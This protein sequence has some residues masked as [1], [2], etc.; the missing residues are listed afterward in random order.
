VVLRGDAL[1]PPLAR[2]AF[3]IVLLDAPCSGTGTLRRRPDKRHRLAAGDIAACAARQAQMLEAA[4]PLV[5]PRGAL[6]YSVCSLEPE[7]GEEQLR[8]FLARHPEFVATDPAGSLG[9]AAEGLVSGDPPA[10][11]TR[12]DL[13]GLDGF[14]AARLVRVAA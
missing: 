14:F 1:A 6:V 9:A 3:G 7:E 8:A 10:L 13:D 5:A 2:A 12:P 11:S 4:A